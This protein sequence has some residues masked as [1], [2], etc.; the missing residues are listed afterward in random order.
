MWSITSI[1]NIRTVSDV[2]RQWHEFFFYHNVSSLLCLSN[3]IMLQI[4]TLKPMCL[5]SELPLAWSSK[6]QTPKERASVMAHSY[7]KNS[8]L[9]ITSHRHL[10]H[11]C[12]LWFISRRLNAYVYCLNFH[13][14]HPQ[15]DSYLHCV[16]QQ[17]KFSHQDSKTCICII[18]HF[19][20]FIIKLGWLERHI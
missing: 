7:G 14:R 5:S 4:K 3:I 17:L 15:R 2:P 11:W 10:V 16:H 19:I 18:K 6:W 8:P 1:H 13:C 20:V 12:Q 9:I